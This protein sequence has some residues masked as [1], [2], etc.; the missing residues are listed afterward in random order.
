MKYHGK[1]AIYLAWDEASYLV[2]PKCGN[3]S[4]EHA[5]ARKIGLPTRR[6]L[7]WRERL[8]Y[9]WGRDPGT[10]PVGWSFTL[11]RDPVDRA[12]SAWFDKTQGRGRGQIWMWVDRY[13]PAFKTGMSLLQWAEAISHIAP[14]EAEDHF[15]PQTLL[16]DRE[17][18]PQFVGL[19][20]EAN[21]WQR[22]RQQT[23]LGA[24]PKRNVS[25]RPQ[26]HEVDPRAVVRLERY[27]AEDY[28][29]LRYRGKK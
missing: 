4:V 15:A 20:D 5:I 22:V 10:G 23:G 14:E 9:G 27:Y 18:W 29:R 1:A 16:L 12:I 21:D 13:G 17:G 11:A 24:L 7:R 3:T 19:L 26:R 2:M 28:R 6:G 25:G 8:L